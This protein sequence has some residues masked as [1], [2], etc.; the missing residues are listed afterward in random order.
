MLVL[1]R[2]PNQSIQIGDNITINVVRVRGNTIKLGIEAPREVPVIRSEL[3]EKKCDGRDASHEVSSK[4]KPIESGTTEAD[5]SKPDT[6]GE[7]GAVM[8][9]IGIDGSVLEFKTAV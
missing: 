2:K 8:R 4:D 1:T 9:V 6:E 3:K 7:P 5:A